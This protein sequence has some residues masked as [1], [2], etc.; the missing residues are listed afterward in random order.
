MRLEERI[1]NARE[2]LK[3]LKAVRDLIRKDDYLMRFED[4]DIEESL[5]YRVSVL[6]EYFEKY[7]EFLKYVEEHPHLEALL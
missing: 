1:G 6:I 4:P 5:V 2:I 7:I 3:H